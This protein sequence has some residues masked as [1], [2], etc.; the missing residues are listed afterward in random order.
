MSQVLGET[1]DVV[2]DIDRRVQALLDDMPPERTPA[3]QFLGEQFDR[4]LAWVHF[5]VGQGGLGLSP[6]IHSRVVVK[7]RDA[8]APSP[9]WRNVIGY[10]MVAPTL[11][12]HG[13]VDQVKRYLR[14]LFIGEEIWCQLF[15]EP[16]A[17]SDVASLSTRAVRDG[18]EWI[19]DGQKVWTTLAHVSKFGLL[20]ART[21]PESP[22]HKGMTC[23]VVDMDAPEVEVRPL[24]QITG[25]AEFNE[26]FFT[27]A[28]VPD[29]Q[30]I[31]GVGDGWNV[32]ITTL[33]NE[34][35]SIGG[36]V[37]GRDKGPI[38]DALRIWNERWK[39]I[40]SPYARAMR[41]R[42]IELFVADGVTQLT[43]RRASDTRRAG[44]PGPEG[45]VA[46]L[47]FAEGNQR[48]YEFCVDLLGAEGTLY[49]STYP[50]LRPTEVTLGSNDA[51]KAF[52]RSRANSI[53]GGTSEV[54]RNILAERVLGLPGE[55][56][57]DKT[58]AW[59]DVPRN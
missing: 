13:T 41:G 38:A 28:R 3:R 25:E 59:K 24:Y 31:G 57:T 29:V 4:G 5:P 58:G 50:K 42:L 10:G 23:F 43:N 22:K 45:S 18:D 27:G 47:A 46:K 34:R 53:E 33:M 9:A 51:R 20:V 54:M 44:T 7:L 12:T 16:G 26:V 48:I 11:V 6:S 21:D 49:G 17:G 37:A 52:L 40:D 8:R 32:V 2:R 15:S 35:V 19:I 14:P 55:V 56:R 39:G 30:R 36:N 1:E